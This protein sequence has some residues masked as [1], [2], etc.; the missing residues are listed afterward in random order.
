MDDKILTFVANMRFKNLY[1]SLS[2]KYQNL[3]LDYKVQFKPRYGHGLPVHQ[4]LE[5][6]IESE[7]DSYRKILAKALDYKEA[8]QEIKTS[9]QEPDPLNPVWD[10]GFLPGLDILGI[11]FMMAQYKPSRYVE[12]GSGTSTKVAYKSKRDNKLSTEITSIDPRPRTEIDR[13]ADRIIREPLEMTDTGFLKDLVAGDILFID[14]SH[15][16]LP[17]SDATVFFLEILP[18]LREGVIVHM[19]DVYLPYDYPQEMCDRYYSEQYGL[20]ICLLSNPSK[21][22]VILPNYYISA[23][24]ELSGI[25]EPVWDHPNLSKTE[26]HGG[27]F[28][29]QIRTGNK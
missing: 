7:R 23:D 9:G 17:N 24:R 14:N 8:I 10:N 13:L 20:A 18:E 2:A 11:Y 19:H 4:G 5:K 12:V 1:R 29:L 28:W 16:I 27:S 26:K 21:Y 15:R 6:I 3:Y 22:R 25:I